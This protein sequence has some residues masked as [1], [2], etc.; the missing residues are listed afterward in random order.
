MG[1]SHVEKNNKMF[2]TQFSIYDQSRTSIL[3]WEYYN[4][5]T[6]NDTIS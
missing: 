4:Y 3:L 2:H 1:V 5:E 6:S